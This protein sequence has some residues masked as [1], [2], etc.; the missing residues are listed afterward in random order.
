MILRNKKVVV[1]QFIFQLRQLHHQGTHILV[2]FSMYL[3]FLSRFAD[4]PNTPD[5]YRLTLWTKWQI[6]DMEMSIYNAKIDVT[7]TVLETIWLYTRR[8]GKTRDLTIVAVF[9]TI[10][11]Y[12][13]A[14]RAP[15]GAQ[16]TKASFWFSINPFVER[17]M[18]KTSNIITVYNSFDISIA[19]LTFG[20]VKGGD[21]DILIFDEG[22]DIPKHLQVYLNYLAARPMVSNSTFKHIINASTPARD[23]AFQESWEN[24]EALEQEYDTVL[25]TIH[26]CE[27]CD[28]IT[29]EF[30]QSESKKYPMW[31]IELN[32]YCKWTVPFGAVF[33]RII[34]IHDPKYLEQP[35]KEHNYAA[36]LASKQPK[37]AGVDHNNGD[38][39]SPHYIVTGDYDENF[40]YVLDEYPFHGNKDD[41]SGLS[42]LFDE[43]FRHVSMEIE[44][45]L[46][47]TQFTKQEMAMGKDA[48]YQ[49]F[50]EDLK[51]ER[52]QEIR[53]RWVIIDKYRCPL[54]YK[55]FL[56]AA[57][58]KNSNKVKLEKRTDQHGLD[59]VIHLMHVSAG[60]IQVYEKTQHA[61]L[62]RPF[63]HYSRSLRV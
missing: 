31:Y 27:D 44:D 54:T 13:V 42:F 1:R 46:W 61:P 62:K 16:L 40:V 17:V 43:R 45:G 18:V 15:Q 19:P 38:R 36:I 53:N 49:E 20:R 34:E 8:G 2:L 12:Q 11:G 29:E 37:L 56:N 14:W 48:I 59:C 41:F 5:K 47:N 22:G 50:S 21:C 25:S 23:T 6:K 60:G 52:V 10:L 26:T 55:N 9:F 7:Q 30:I 28:W 32:Y 35:T 3:G 39:N 24:V 57:Y 63:G 33:E 4:R 51:M 58:D